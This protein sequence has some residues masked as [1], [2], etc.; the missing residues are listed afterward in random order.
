MTACTC[1]T[2]NWPSLDDNIEVT[3]ALGLETFEHFQKA[4][5]CISSLEFVLRTCSI[6]PH[7]AASPTRALVR[8]Q[9]QQLGAVLGVGASVHS[10]TKICV[11]PMGKEIQSE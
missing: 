1:H 6:H 10:S 4:L 7:V 3:Q 2:L 8:T 9:C 11:P 5:G